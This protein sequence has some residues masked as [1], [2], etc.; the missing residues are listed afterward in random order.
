MGENGPSVLHR[1]YEEPSLY[2]IKPTI[3]KAKKEEKAAKSPALIA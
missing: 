2:R 3:T 1:S